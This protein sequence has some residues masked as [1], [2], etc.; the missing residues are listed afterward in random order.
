MKGFGEWMVQIYFTL[1]R[2]WF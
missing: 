2:E 1:M